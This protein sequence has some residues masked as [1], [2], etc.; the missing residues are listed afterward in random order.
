MAV[1]PWAYL[2]L[3]VFRCE[4]CAKPVAMSLTSEEANLENVDAQSFYAQCECGW[5]KALLGSDA[6]SHSV[7][8]WESA[9]TEG[10]L[11]DRTA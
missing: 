5:L 1:E 6:I 3:L 7:A 2:H 4:Q 9:S 8:P 10:H 11:G